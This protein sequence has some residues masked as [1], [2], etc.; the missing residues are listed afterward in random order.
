MQAVST[1]TI[2][3]LVVYDRVSHVIV[4]KLLWVL[5]GGDHSAL[6]PANPLPVEVDDTVEQIRLAAWRLSPT[7]RWPGTSS[8]TTT[9]LISSLLI[10]V[11]VGAGRV[12]WV[13]VR[14]ALDAARL[15]TDSLAGTTPGTGSCQLDPYRQARVL[16][17]GARRTSP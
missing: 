2:F 1:L 14:P 11:Q 4:V 3:C 16:Q 9:S 6:E 10:A 17:L 12:V 13:A 5:V 7:T 15:R 8:S